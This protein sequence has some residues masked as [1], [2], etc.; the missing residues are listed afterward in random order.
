M[1]RLRAVLWLDTIALAL[2]YTAAG[3]LYY[4]VRQ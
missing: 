3:T 4:T 2:I 1:I